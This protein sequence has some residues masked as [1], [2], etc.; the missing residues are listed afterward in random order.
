MRATALALIVI[1]SALASA[2]QGNHESDIAVPTSSPSSKQPSASPQPMTPSPA[3]ISEPSAGN[4]LS[5]ACTDL[6]GV[7]G[8]W[9]NIDGEIAS[10]LAQQVSRAISEV[11]AANGKITGLQISSNGGDI[12]EALKLGRLVRTLE[13][14]V[15]IPK[16]SVCYSSCVL[17]L[18]GAVSR[19]PLGRVGIHRPYFADGA[20]STDDARSA[21]ASIRPEIIQFLQD[22]GVSAGLWDDM[23]AIPAE[24]IRELSFPELERYGLLGNDPSFEEK[25]AR[26]RMQWFGIDRAELNRRIADGKTECAALHPEVMIDRAMCTQTYLQK[27]HP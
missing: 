27:G 19:H 17:V 1:T 2:C 5:Q 15:V 8:C 6:S 26:Q 9:I 11:R 18:A 13:V 7:N 3:K 14:M 24:Q 16:D 10:G 23:V 22:G 12:N 4:V 25:R 21:Y 20:A